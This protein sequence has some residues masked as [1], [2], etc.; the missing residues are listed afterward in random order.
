MRGTAQ[1]RSNAPAYIT[2]AKEKRMLTLDDIRGFYKFILGREMNPQEVIATDLHM[3]AVVNEQFEMARRKFLDSDEFFSIL[4]ESFYDKLMPNSKIVLYKTDMNFEIYLDLRQLHVTLG[5]IN[6]NYERAEI[7]LL[8]RAV[9]RTDTFI[10]VGGNAGYYSLAIASKPDFEGRVVAF[11]PLTSIRSLFQRSVEFNDLQSRIRILPF[12][13]AAEP[14]SMAIVHSENSM[15]I[16]GSHL[17]RSDKIPNSY[18]EYVAVETL[19]RIAVDLKLERIDVMKIDIEGAEGLFFAGARQMIERDLPTM[20]VEVNTSQLQE[21]SGWGPDDLINWLSERGYQ[22][23][24]V[25]PTSLVPVATGAGLSRVMPL[26]SILNVF[27]VHESRIDETRMLI[28]ELQEII[29]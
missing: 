14:G 2:Q 22:V 5:I 13:L 26:S 28:P 18:H 27:C 21:L 6:D 15:N 12:A 17:S 1:G 9:R 19:D 10:D 4:L 20:L 23:T 11:E 8:R 3:E 16:G 7:G 25:L 29:K 24:A